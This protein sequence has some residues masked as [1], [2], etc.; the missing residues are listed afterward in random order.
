MK[1]YVKIIVKG[2]VQGVGYRYY[3]LIEAKKL[4]VAGYVTNLPSGDVGVQA[5]GEDEKLLR[6]I[7]ALKKGP[8]FSKVIDLNIEYGEYKNRFKEFKV[9]Y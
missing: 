6:F 7:K 8:V 4:G 2:R 3:T 5:E 9:I 1:S